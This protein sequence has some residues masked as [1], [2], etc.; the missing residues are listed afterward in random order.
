MDALTPLQCTD[1]PDDNTDYHAMLV[2]LVCA[3]NGDK[4]SGV[5]VSV[6]SALSSTGSGGGAGPWG[7]SHTEPLAR[8]AVPCQ[9]SCGQFKGSLLPVCYFMLSLVDGTYAARSC[10]TRMKHTPAFAEHDIVIYTSK[11]WSA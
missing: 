4:A 3:D 8:W 6:Y 7:R 2:V 1:G 5:D 9:V 10:A 11:H